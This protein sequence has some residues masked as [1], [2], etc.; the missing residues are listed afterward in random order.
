MAVYATFTIRYPTI[1][2]FSQIAFVLRA[3]AECVYSF[4][5]VSAFSNKNVACNMNSQSCITRLKDIKV[6]D[7]KYVAR[8]ETLKK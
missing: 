4:D 8:I 2:I 6:C 1:S 3:V 7:N 5:N